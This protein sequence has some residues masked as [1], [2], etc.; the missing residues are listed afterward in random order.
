LDNEEA[1]VR[2]I[3][4]NPTQEDKDWEAELKRHGVDS[5]RMKEIDQLIEQK[6]EEGEL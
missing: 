6:R 4:Y 2:E 3:G 1:L 5:K